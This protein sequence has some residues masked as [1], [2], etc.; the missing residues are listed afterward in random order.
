MPLARG[1][2]ASF[3][4]SLWMTGSPEL[5]PGGLHD[6]AFCADIPISLRP[7]IKGRSHRG[8]HGRGHERQRWD[9]GIRQP[10][11]GHW[12]TMIMSANRRP[13]G[14]PAVLTGLS[15]MGWRSS[16]F[17]DSPPSPEP[18]RSPTVCAARGSTIRSLG[19]WQCPLPASHH[20]VPC[21]SLRLHPWPYEIP[22][23]AAASQPLLNSM[24]P[25][26]SIVTGI[27]RESW[28]LLAPK[29]SP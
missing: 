21:P 4:G 28:H 9:M 23:N 26:M 18:S 3:L 29:V 16:S 25:A 12:R 5:Y 24:T 11:L 6:L 15:T 7:C 20:A 22:R 2:P 8:N 27:S 10:V 14:A 17:V 1:I 19:L 13:A